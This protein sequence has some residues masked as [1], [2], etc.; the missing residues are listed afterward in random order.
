MISV[1]L[2]TNL[3]WITLSNLLVLMEAIADE[4]HRTQYYEQV[5]EGS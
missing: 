4:S 3:L 5:V 2:L 1:S